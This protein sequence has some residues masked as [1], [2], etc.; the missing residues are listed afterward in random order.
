MFRGSEDSYFDFSGGFASNKPASNIAPNEAQSLR[1]ILIITGKGIEKRRGNTLFNSSAMSSGAAVTGLFYYKQSGGSDFLVATAGAAI[2]KADALDGTMDDITGAVTITSNQNNLWTACQMNDLAI[3]VGGAP[4][5]PIKYSGTG[6][7]AALGG[8]PPSGSFGFTHNN[9]MFIG[10][11]SANPSLIQ[12][13]ILGNPED[14]SA[15]GSGSQQIEKNDGD[16]LVGA[17]PLSTDNVLLFKQNSIHQFITRSSPFPYFPLFKGVGAVGKRAIVTVNGLVYFIT[18]TARM[19]ITDGNRVLDESDIPRLGNIDDIWDSLN[20]SRLQYITGI[21]QSGAGF[22]HVVWFCSSS[23]SSSNDIALVWDI[24][25]KCWLE[26]TS[27]YKANSAANTQNGTLYTGHYNG[28]IY[29]QDVASTYADASETSPGA[30]DAY[31]SSNWKN[32]NSLSESVH[33]VRLNVALTS[34]T[35]GVLTIGYGRDYTSDIYT[36]SASMQ[37]KGDN[38]DEMLWDAGTWGVQSDL[39]KK[40][41]TKGRGLNYQV[42]FGNRIVNQTFQIH[43]Y[44]FLVKKTGQK[45][46]ETV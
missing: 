14:W 40:L 46:F 36:E 26:H 45:S 9:R 3:F 11:T 31:W 21:Y 10:N 13:S 39:I 24:R 37:G 17:A 44:S 7:A 1:N 4:N 23:G 30:I 33:P 8:S 2:F 34:Q 27:G 38:W 20:Q 41:S 43:G 22:D 19:R 15:S 28:K 18:P 16:V 5:S 6:N 35:S 25:N 42:S 32:T 12:W 29:Q